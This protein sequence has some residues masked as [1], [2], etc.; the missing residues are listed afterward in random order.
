[1]SSFTA[2][3]QTKGERNCREQKPFADKPHP[4]PRNAAPATYWSSDNVL[5][6]VYLYIYYI[7]ISYHIYVYYLSIYLYIYN[8]TNYGSLADSCV[9]VFQQ[10]TRDNLCIFFWHFCDLLKFFPKAPVKGFFPKNCCQIQLFHFIY[11]TSPYIS[12]HLPHCVWESVENIQKSFCVT[13]AILFAWFSEHKLYFSWQAQHFGGVHCSFLRGTRSTLDVVVLRIFL[14][15][16]LAGWVKWWHR[17]NYVAYMA[18][19]DMW[20]KLTEASHETPIL[21]WQILGFIRNL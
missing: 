8:K 21:R 13:G 17:A 6:H 1:M 15:I 4:T 12:L 20:W 3:R 5:E 14:R 7:Y 18:L 9:F 11:I 16:A 2:V 10:N 19:C